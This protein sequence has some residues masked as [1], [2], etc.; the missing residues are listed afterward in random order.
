MAQYYVIVLNIYFLTTILEPT[1]TFSKHRH[2][3]PSAQFSV[4]S[5]PRP[6]KAN[7]IGKTGKFLANRFPLGSLE[8]GKVTFDSN[9]RAAADVN[10]AIAV[11]GRA[12]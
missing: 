4:E 11:I 6:S 7:Y 1:V 12:P 5:G 2:S 8:G 3:C 10:T 9:E